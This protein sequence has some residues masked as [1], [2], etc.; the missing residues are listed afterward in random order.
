MGQLELSLPETE[1]PPRKSQQ[2]QESIQL[3]W[4]KAMEAYSH[5]IED[6]ET[7]TG[8]RLKQ[9]QE[10]PTTFGAFELSVSMMRALHRHLPKETA[11]VINS[12]TGK[13]STVTTQVV[14]Q[15]IKEEISQGNTWTRPIAIAIADTGS[16][17]PE[18]ANRMEEEEKAFQKLGETLGIPLEA[19]RIMPP[20][21]HRLLVEL[22]GNGK[23][24][25]AVS[26]TGKGQGVSA[27]C[28][29]RVKAGTL[30]E[31]ARRMRKKH[32]SYVSILGVRSA[33]SIKRKKTISRYSD[34]MPF[35]LSKISEGTKKAL[36][37]T[38]IVHWENDAVSDWIRNFAPVWRPQGRE[39]LR[40]IYLKGS[41]LEGDQDYKPS[42]CQ[43]TISNEGAVS[44]SCSDLS[45][46][47]Y[48]CW[49]C[50]Q[51]CNKS[52]K[53]TSRRD[54]RYHWLRKFHAYIYN[55]GKEAIRRSI[56]LKKLGF[57]RENSFTKTFTFKERYRM[58]MFVYRCEL[59][60]G[61]QLLR[62]EEEKAIEDLWLKHGIF[63]VTTQ[64]AKE[65]AKIWKKT[66]VWKGF[67]EKI[68]DESHRVCEALSEGI[69]YG[70][71]YGLKA[72]NIHNF[73]LTEDVRKSRTRG[74]EL[75][76]LLALAG[77]GHGSPP[78]PKTLAHVYA[79]TKNGE[80][81]GIV[82][83]IS[84]TPTLLGLPTNTGLLNGMCGAHW[85][86]IGTREPLT[87]ERKLA[88]DRNFAYKINTKVP[89]KETPAIH[90]PENQWTEWKY[91]LNVLQSGVS[92][93]PFKDEWFDI[94]LIQS[95]RKMDKEEFKAVFELTRELTYLSDQLTDHFQ[96]KKIK[97][98]KE[99]RQELLTMLQGGETPKT[100]QKR[101]R[102]TVRKTLQLEEMEP[103]LKEYAKG[104]QLAAKAA[105]NNLLNTSLLLKLSMIHRFEP[106]DPHEAQRLLQNLLRLVKFKDRQHVKQAA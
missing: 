87:W 36:A 13:D 61:L 74:L 103:L 66:G 11:W 92:D 30:K 97:I 80:V 94:Q 84:D 22:C 81:E 4:M 82:T 93:D 102:D 19:H 62:P 60:S 43:V 49:H 89:L 53:N 104:M 38:P 12:S 25:P 17:F 98:Q 65:D 48:G 26:E 21:K 73:Q 56:R 16:E 71:L 77:E 78:L 28:M 29:D 79:D 105:R 46:T 50:F 67:F 59:E 24:V 7:E 51:S 20:P 9:Y 99:V 72:C 15:A 52:L 76:H 1:K 8:R 68:E 18:M 91:Q 3:S 100:S 34:E 88:D 58:L 95:L 14:I 45:G 5:E 70:A 106:I 86:L 55:K 90:F 23:P 39:E 47:R 44:N 32:G 42:E 54:E 57:T 40:S 96:S 27:W 64:N 41:P 83:V 2:P 6:E 35:G 101:V 69:P 10:R 33:E 31:I 63:C 85:K 75:V 37:C